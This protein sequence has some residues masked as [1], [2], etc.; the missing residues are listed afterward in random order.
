[1]EMEFWGAVIP[2]GLTMKVE[3]EEAEEFV[4]VTQVALAADA[5]PGRCALTDRR[6]GDQHVL[7]TLDKGKCDQVGLTSSWTRSSRSRTT[8]PTRCTSPACVRPPTASTRPRRRMRSSASPPCSAMEDT[9][10]EEQDT[11]SDDE[12]EDSKEGE[13]EGDDSEE[14]EDGWKRRARIRGLRGGRRPRPARGDVQVR[15]RSRPERGG[16]EAGAAAARRRR[17]EDGQLG[18]Q[19]DDVLG[20]LVDMFKEKNGRDPSEAE[21]AQWAKTLK[22][23]AAE[24]GD[25]EDGE[26][27]RRRV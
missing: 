15:E 22:E 16:D 24:D 10:E 13:S 7:C 8:A 23:A 6:R 12:G 14:E 11:S 25:D 4:H 20:Q 26:R 3:V 17:G 9:G 19:A 2:P 5:K 21:L 18:E 27:G 1:M